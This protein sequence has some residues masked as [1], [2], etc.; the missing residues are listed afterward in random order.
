MS[1]QI[2]LFNDTAYTKRFPIYVKERQVK[3]EWGVSGRGRKIDREKQI[4]RVGDG[5]MERLGNGVG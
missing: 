4:N 2:T 1:F 5:A 3:I